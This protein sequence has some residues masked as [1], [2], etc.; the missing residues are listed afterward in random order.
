MDNIVSKKELETA[1]SQAMERFVEEQ[2]G[3]C[4]RKVVTSVMKDVI[5][6]RIKSNLIPAERYMMRYQK[7]SEIIRELKIKLI[8]RAKPLLDAMIKN[9]T[10]ADI[11][12]LHSDVCV[13]T[14]ERVE[15]F[16]LKK[17]IE[18]ETSS[19]NKRKKK[20]KGSNA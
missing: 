18:K 1:I 19:T 6:V 3:E 15:I 11:I 2:M 13:E 14:G 4:P 5:I 17:D 16:T 9:L 20:E 12:D 10:G 8:E 7:G